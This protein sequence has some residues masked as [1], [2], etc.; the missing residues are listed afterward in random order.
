MSN[1]QT[2]S[3]E[4]IDK[5]HLFG[6]YQKAED[7]QDALYR[8]VVHKS[9][10]MPHHDD[11]NIDNRKYTFGDPVSKK[12]TTLFAGL[13]MGAAG[14]FGMNAYN[15]GQSLEKQ[16]PPRE[17]IVVPTKDID[18]GLGKIKDY[19]GLNLAN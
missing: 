9:L 11:M 12:L 3:S 5:D 15:Q 4:E 10:D 13:A 19:P 1:A 14:V 2:E 17:E 6:R 7:W 16:L 18:M 8:K